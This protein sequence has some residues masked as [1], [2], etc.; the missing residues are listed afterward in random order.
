MVRRIWQYIQFPNLFRE[1]SE[2]DE[3]LNLTVVVQTGDVT[4]VPYDRTR[5]HQGSFF[6]I[7]VSIRYQQLYADSDSKRIL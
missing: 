7:P 5:V 1:S 4:L 6:F 3:Y 2:C